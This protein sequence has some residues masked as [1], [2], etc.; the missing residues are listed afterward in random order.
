MDHVFLLRMK[1]TADV[2]IN[3]IILY[4]PTSN[5]Y[6]SKLLPASNNLMFLENPLNVFHEEMKNIHL[7]LVFGAM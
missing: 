4:T 1:Y 7:A 5:I 3:Y 6:Y 2:S